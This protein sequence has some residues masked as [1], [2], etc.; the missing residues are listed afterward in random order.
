MIVLFDGGGEVVC[1]NQRGNI[2]WENRSGER[3]E[4]NSSS[5]RIECHH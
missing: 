1:L 4:A 2:L 3:G 5:R